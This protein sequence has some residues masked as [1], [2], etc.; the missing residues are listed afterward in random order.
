[1]PHAACRM[2]CCMQVYEYAQLFMQ[3]TWPHFGPKSASRILNWI[4]LLCG[5][6]FVYRYLSFV[7][8]HSPPS[9]SSACQYERW[10]SHFPPDLGATRISHFTFLQ[11]RQL[12]HINCQL[13]CIP[14]P[15]LAVARCGRG[16]G[17]CH[18]HIAFA[19]LERMM[20]WCIVCACGMKDCCGHPKWQLLNWKQ[21]ASSPVSL[22]RTLHLCRALT[23]SFVAHMVS[24]TYE[25]LCINETQRCL[26]N[27]SK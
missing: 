27:Q 15:L 6:T 14:F 2:P 12:Q 8:S 4:K 11:L 7:Y 20:H 5:T 23:F 17:S 21:Q 13:C 18:L 16:R 19:Y 9:T 22:S 3:Q 24:I 1:M 10:V 26:D 25:I